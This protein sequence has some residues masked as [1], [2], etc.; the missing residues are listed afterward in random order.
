M[1]VKTVCSLMGGDWPPGPQPVN[2]PA[3]NPPINTNRML[4][5][6]F[7]WAAGKVQPSI[8]A[9]MMMHKPM[10]TAAA[11]MAAAMFLFSRISLLR[12]PGVHLS[13]SL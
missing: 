1:L 7:T 4:R 5:L 13:N 10:I 9:A 2:A 6:R 8:A 11:M 12:S 3:D